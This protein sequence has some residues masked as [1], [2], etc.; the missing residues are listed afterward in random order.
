VGSGTQIPLN[1]RRSYFRVGVPPEVVPLANSTPSQ[2]TR[3]WSKGFQY[4][5]IS[6][7]A[8]FPLRGEVSGTTSISYEGYNQREVIVLSD[9]PIVQGYQACVAGH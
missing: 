1:R 3:F 8:A 6:V 2:G 9:A 4:G 7:S 5:G